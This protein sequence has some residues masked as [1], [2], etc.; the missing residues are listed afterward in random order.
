MTPE[1]S[2]EDEV[3]AN[4]NF[5]LITE[6]KDLHLSVDEAITSLLRL[7]VQI[8][9]SSRKAK[10]AKS[11]VDK[12]YAIDPDIS[13][14]LDFFPHLDTTGNV[15]LAERLGKAN[16]QRRQW[17][18]YRRRHRE[19]LSVDFSG[20]APNAMPPLGE[21][22]E[23]HRVQGQ[24]AD[25][26]IIA[27]FSVDEEGSGANWTPSLVSDTKASTFR[28]RPTAGSLLSPSNA[29]PETL[30]GR[31]SKAAASEQKLLAPQPPHD[32]VLNQPYSCRYC[33]NIVEISGRHAW[34]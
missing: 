23:G 13:H 26:E 31:S 9:K 19:K 30:F 33:C 4:V 7:S 25:T 34:Q 17:L 24:Y 5:E 16:A 29:P 28:S 32:L 1:S 2:P 20:A 14:A 18:W 8:H 12:D 21:W 6:S 10:F 15:A 3:Q 11:S 27:L 22:S